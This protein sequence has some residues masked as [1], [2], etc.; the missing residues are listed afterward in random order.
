M[1]LSDSFLRRPRFFTSVAAL[2][3]AVGVEGGA[4]AQATDDAGLMSGHPVAD[5]DALADLSLEELLNTTVTTAS[6]EEETER[7][8]PSAITV[9]TRKE[10]RALGVR[11]LD[12]LLTLVPGFDVRPTNQIDVRGISSV[13]NSRVLLMIDG[14]PMDD[15]YYGGPGKTTDLVNLEYVERVEIIRGPGSALYGTNAFAGVI[16]VTT[17]TRES[18]S[19]APAVALSAGAGTVPDGQGTALFGKQFGPFRA[20]TYVDYRRAGGPTYELHP[21]DLGR[22]G[23]I[24]QKKDDL[25]AGVKLAYEQTAQLSV[26]YLRR[27]HAGLITTDNTLMPDSGYTT[28]WLGSSLEVEHRSDDFDAKAKLFGAWDRWRD[29]DLMLVFPRVNPLFENG[30][31]DHP[32]L[33]MLRGGLDVYG[34]YVA[35]K[36]SVMVGALV[37]LVASPSLPVDAPTDGRDGPNAGFDDVLM[38]QKTRNIFGA[39]LQYRWDIVESLKLTAGGRVDHYGDFGATVNPRMALVSTPTDE[40][41]GKAILGSAFRA[42]AFRECCSNP[43]DY[44]VA[45]PDLQPERVVTTEVVLGTRPVPSVDFHIGGFRNKASD[46]IW[47]APLLSGNRVVFRNVPG[48]N[49]LGSEAELTA[50]VAEPF[51]VRANYTYVTGWTNTP[52]VD[53]EVPLIAHHLANLVLLGDFID[54]LQ[55]TPSLQ[56]R[57]TRYRNR[58]GG[59]PRPDLEPY[60]LLNGN[61]RVYDVLADNLEFDI[62]VNNVLDQKYQGPSNYPGRNPMVTP[63]DIPAPGIEAFGSVRYGFL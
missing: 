49:T 60:F 53:S 5:L 2:L 58:Q 50:Q 10:I 1:T 45:N 6:K 20:S 16:S 8:S 51:A 30:I 24:T 4:L 57:G 35:G 48:F 39:Y 13:F 41:Y 46:I 22:S 11:T 62:L 36:H 9:F 14:V 7:E 26:N 23:D 55:V 3:G 61:V 54:H 52:G 40:V 18:G 21:R 38:E 42:P 15:A 28:D 34:R 17:R 44:M 33:E 47:S 56:Y 25:S 27:E 43:N 19:T 37:E 63:A 31:Y 29:V 12:E 59:D 32:E